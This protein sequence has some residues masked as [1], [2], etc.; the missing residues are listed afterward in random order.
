MKLAFRFDWIVLA[1]AIWLY[2]S[3]FVF[4]TATLAY[5]ATALAW[6][7]AV[8]LLVSSS[9]A[10][11]VPDVV[12]QWMDV[13]VGLALVAGPWLLGFDGDSVPATNSVIVG[14]VVCACAIAG[15]IRDR[16]SRAGA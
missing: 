12:E 8:A 2:A 13:V 1:S 7:C 3:P 15:V 9:E 16:G 6:V 11:T 4:G 10:L 5:P 14:I